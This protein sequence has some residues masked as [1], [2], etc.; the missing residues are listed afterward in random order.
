M[1]L[2]KLT[3]SE[4]LEW[5][6]WEVP[7][8][9]S[10]LRRDGDRRILLRPVDVERRLLSVRRTTVAPPEWIHGWVCF[11][12][13]STKLRLCPRPDDWGSVPPEQLERYKH[14]AQPVR[15]SS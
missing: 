9:F 1:L 5:Q 4:G 15:S 10:S 3:D 2:R 6:V 13:G 12:S 8:R 7:S 11:Q 14:L